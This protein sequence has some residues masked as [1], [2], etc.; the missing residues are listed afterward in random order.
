MG[1]DLPAEVFLPPDLNQLLHPHLRCAAIALLAEAGEG[2]IFFLPV[3]KLP[4]LCV[5]MSFW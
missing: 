4:E 5:P 3:F 1:T 2:E